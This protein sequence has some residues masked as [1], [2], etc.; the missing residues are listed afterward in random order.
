MVNGELLLRI[1]CLQVQAQM[2]THKNTTDKLTKRHGLTRDHNTPNTQCYNFLLHNISFHFNFFNAK[3]NKL[4]LTALICSHYITNDIHM[5]NA[6][7]G[8]F[9]LYIHGLFFTL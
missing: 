9:I 3:K 4:N 2:K 6:Q 5:R 7:A 8:G 1:N